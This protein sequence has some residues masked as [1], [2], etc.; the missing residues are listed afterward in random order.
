MGHTNTKNIVHLKFKIL[1]AKPGN[2]LPTPYFKICHSPYNEVPGNH[3][4]GLGS[5]AIYSTKQE[6]KVVKNMDDFFLSLP[7]YFERERERE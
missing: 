1:F 4:R 5:L 3:H 2:L 6:F 7:I